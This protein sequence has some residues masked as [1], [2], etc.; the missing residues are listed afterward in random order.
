MPFWVP[1][2]MAAAGAGLGALTNK[3]NRLKGALL[4][5]GL[6]AAGGMGLNAAGVGA[7][8]SGIGPFASGAKYGA[9]LSGKTA[10]GLK[11]MLTAEKLKGLQQWGQVL[12][13][14]QQQDEDYIQL[15]GMEAQPMPIAGLN[16]QMNPFEP[17]MPFG[18]MKRPRPML[19]D[20]MMRYYS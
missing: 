3:K 13:G 16:N 7:G 4:G 5:A 19:T 9:A 18:N 12:S 15:R 8:T 6:G 2:A 14:P 10:G 11:G 17:V 1:L 20:A